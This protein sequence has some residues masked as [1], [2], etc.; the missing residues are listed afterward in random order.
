MDDEQGYPH[1][2]GNLRFQLRFCTWFLFV[3][4]YR[5]SDS[6][7]VIPIVTHHGCHLEP[8]WM[9]YNSGGEQHPFP[10]GFV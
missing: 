6:P 9:K 5:V 8:H 10:S 7:S 1:D 4:S 3:V 2:L